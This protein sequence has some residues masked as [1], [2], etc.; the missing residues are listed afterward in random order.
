MRGPPAIL[1][2]RLVVKNLPDS[3]ETV[4]VIESTTLCSFEEPNGG[5][6]GRRTY[7]GASSRTSVSIVAEWC[8]GTFCIWA[9]TIRRRRRPGARRSRCSTQM[10]VAVRRWPC[11]PTTVAMRSRQTPRWFGFPWP[12]C[13]C[14]VRANG[15]PVGWP[16]LPRF[17]IKETSASRTFATFVV[18]Y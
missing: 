3:H 7:I 16:V 15:V 13:A 8:S 10:R 18:G 14:I 4:F 12:N 1:S 5:R 2:K 11:S 6:T 17:R 9:R